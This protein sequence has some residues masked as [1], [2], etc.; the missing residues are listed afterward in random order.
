LGEV[1]AQEA[2]RADM[3]V[4]VPDSAIPARLASAVLG[5]LQRGLTKNRYIGR[6][7]IQPDDRLRKTGVG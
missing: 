4:G 6:T 3:I 1:L 7:F 2:P 5:P